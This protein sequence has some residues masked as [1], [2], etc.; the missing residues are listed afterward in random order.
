MPKTNTV[1]DKL[2]VVDG[3]TFAEIAVTGTSD[4]E[5]LVIKGDA[6]Q[7]KNLT[8]WQNSAGTVLAQITAEGKMQTDKGIRADSTAW[9]DALGV[10]TGAEKL[11]A[12]V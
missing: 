12:G 2:V 4:T 1:S 3:Q 6:S 10:W 9:V 11:V 8:Q 7:T 5:Q